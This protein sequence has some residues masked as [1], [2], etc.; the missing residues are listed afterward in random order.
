VVGPLVTLESASAQSSGAGKSASAA[1]AH[2]EAQLDEL[3]LKESDLA[4]L[5]VSDVVPVTDGV[6]VVHVQ[7][8]LDGIDIHGA[9]SNVVVAAD[10]EVLSLGDRFEGAAAERSN[11]S[12]PKL[13]DVQAAGRAAAALGLRPTEAFQPRS[14]ARGPERARELSDGGVS[15]EAVPVRLVHQP[16]EDGTIRLAWDVGIYELDQENYWHVRVDAA[17]GQEL[18]RH[19]LVIHDHF[20]E[21]GH[22]EDE[23][24]HVSAEPAEAHLDDEGE[25]GG[26]EGERADAG[27]GEATDAIDDRASPGAPATAEA[28]E[29]DE[30]SE[31]DLAE[32]SVG[33]GSY[34]VYDAPVEAPSF[35][36][37]T[38]VNDPADA[39]ASPFGWHDTN[40]VAGP[41]FTIT[42][43]NN[44]H[45]YLDTNNS[46][47][48]DPD[49]EPDGGPSLIFDFPIDLTQQPN[50]YQPA[51]VTNLFYWN[52]LVHDVF[53]HYGFDEP[54]GNFQVN[55]YGRGGLGNDDV[56]AEAQDGGGTN[57]ANFFTPADGSRARM[58]MYL[59]NL[60][61][62]MRD[63]DL[64]NGIIAHEYSHGISIRLTGGPSNVGCLTN[65]EQGGEGWSDWT[66]L[67]MTQRPTDTAAQVRGI[68]TYALGQATNGPGIRQYPYTTDMD[69]NP[70][71]YDDIKT[72]AIPHGV[73]SVWG[74][75]LW[76]VTWSLID[77]HGFDPALIGG[78]GGNNLALQLI[79]DGMK[80]QPCSPGF[81][82]A[83]DAILLADT[84]RTGGQNTC[85]LWDAFAKR[86]LGFSA[87]QGSSGSRSDGTEAFDVPGVCQPIELLKTANP[88][89]LAAGGTITYQLTARNNLDTPLQAVITDPIPG[90]ATY[91][92]GSATC[93]GTFDG[94]AVTMNTT[95]PPLSE[96][97]CSLQV[98]SDAAPWSQTLYA[99]SFDTGTTGWAMTHGG[100]T[101]VTWALTDTDPF[102]APNAMLAT[103]PPTVSDQRLTTTSSLPIPPDAVL[104]FQ[105]RYQTEAGFDGG[106]VEITDDGGSTWQD[107]GPHMIQNGY[108]R[109]LSSCCD[110]PLPGRQAFSGNSGAYL[111][112]VV[113][114][115]SFESDHVRFRFRMGTDSSIGGVGWRVDDVEV[116][117]DVAVT[118][119]ATLSV[120]GHDDVE[121]SVRSTLEEPGP[122][123]DLRVSSIADPPTSRAQGT[124]FQVTDST[125]NAGLADA[126]GSRTRYYL[127]RFTT[128]GASAQL[129]TGVRNIGPLAAGATNSGSRNVTIPLEM[130]TGN[131]WLFA[132][133]D[134][135]GLVVESNEGNNCRRA[136]GN[137]IT[138]TQALPDLRVPAVADPPTSAEQGTTFQ[139]SDTTRNFGL[140]GA[141]TSRT[142]YYLS[143]STTLGAD[144]RRLSGARVVPALAAGEAHAGSRT[145]TVPLNTPPA[146]YWLFACADDTELVTES[147]E[148]NNCRRAT[149]NQ[150]VVTP[151]L[152][153]L[154]VSSFSDPP[155]AGDQGS[156]FTVTDTTRNDGSAEAA[157]SRTRY[158]LSLT[159]MQDGAVRQLTG[160]RVVPILAPGEE[161]TGSRTV[162]IPSDV[163]PGDYWVFACADASNLV[164]E[165]NE[166]NNCLRTSSRITVTVPLP[167]LR[168]TAV[169]DP[170]T[171]GLQGDTF[172][173]TDTTR[174]EGPGPAGASRNRH[175]LS[176]SNT[177]D[178]TAR[179]LAGNRLVPELAAGATSTGTRTVT[180]PSNLA[181]GRYWLY[182][183]ADD[184]N[185]VIETN[186]DNNCRRATGNRIHVTAAPASNIR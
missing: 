51:A 165:S 60:T 44:V 18:D 125:R 4:D 127:S 185:L 9:L 30:G 40:G 156:S 171:G 111:Q 61:N 23:D 166:A 1:L 162:T 92:P 7:Q 27:G 13:T 163:A 164:T 69:I 68:G 103:D 173:V 2:L 63:G 48:P 113:D 133:A 74:A 95:L 104:Q 96:I 99:D 178:A 53:Y 21:P 73:G 138:V 94:T 100:G 154:L 10:G 161:S 70:H 64:D 137:R 98:T 34:R 114:L 159:D 108:N 109:T 105:H 65:A 170:P 152:P 144:G 177:F 47:T 86:G 90:N 168:I 75:M 110:N 172:E 150:V 19:N 151:P 101:P 12:T 35:G 37:R 155:A 83:R 49:G 59:W 87:D 89:T 32:T 54:S 17:T 115:S 122:L 62:P 121:A 126:G 5:A 66:G 45:A 33:G 186:E 3:G 145:V 55:N 123:P 77:E 179:R 120:P 20:G 119:I 14:S 148:T 160:Q 112:T 140:V 131:Y 183:C 36:T 88:T 6:Q 142:R 84:I 117:T 52:N 57:N 175:Y 76:D 129:L 181:V 80:I 153:D 147:N 139:V 182:S 46:G 15:L 38:L 184:T 180:I 107:L 149:G 141:G 42:R 31:E 169:S 116:R 78:T 72:V 22:D 97:V 39:L 43:G 143:T 82:D 176:L 25:E 135:T 102:S 106:V 85:L 93:G 174:N 157:S 128:F 134:D 91:E 136:T 41:E 81:V 58:Q 167:D 158:Y 29:E 118:N 56:R 71:T 146:S 28:L 50:T 132:C 79:T 67:I 16:L 11:G 130:P 124:T 24:A 26:D 8:R